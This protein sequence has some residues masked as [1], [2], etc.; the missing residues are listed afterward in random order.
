M[1]ILSIVVQS[2]LL[3]WMV[4]QGASKIAGQKMQVE[5]F[6]SI[7]LPQWFRVVTGVVQLVGCAALI[8]GYWY[9]G[10]AA[11]A[12]LCFGIMMVLAI[13]LHV[14]VKEPFAKLAPAIVTFVIAAG[15]FVL[16]LD[17]MWQ[18]FA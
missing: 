4:F 13:L 11:W 2:W 17:D 15:V 5:L 7:R 10:V 9:P 1:H 18:P 12:G 8:I 3:L 6:Q 14:R 16:F